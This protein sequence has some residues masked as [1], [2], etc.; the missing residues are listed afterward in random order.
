MSREFHIF[1]SEADGRFL[2]KSIGEGYPREF[3]SLFEATRHARMH[4]GSAGGLMVI[5]DEDENAVNRIPFR[6]CM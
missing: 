6:H 4:S 2:V 5:Y 1:V 3:P